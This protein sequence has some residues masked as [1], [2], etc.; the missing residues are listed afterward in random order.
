MFYLSKIAWAFFQPSTFIAVVFVAGL[1]LALAGRSRFGTWLLAAATLLYLICG[2]SPLGVWLLEPL[3]SWASPASD[4]ELS[5][6]AGIIVLGGG[7]ARTVKG[8]APQLNEAGERMV[9]TVRLARRFPSMTIVF[10][11]GR[12]E[13][14]EDESL[15]TEA[16]SA[17]QFLSV[18]DIS[19]PR[20]KL[21]D[22]SRNTFENAVF[23][24]RVVA[25][26]PGQPWILVTSAF[27]MPRAALL[28]EKQG[29]TIL[30]RPTDFRTTSGVRPARFFLRAGQGFDQVD[31]A[32]K[33]WVAI[34]VYWLRG[35]I[36]WP[37]KLFCGIC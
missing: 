7:M 23:T 27:H 31:L 22:S 21:E 13:L 20:L 16:A 36:A 30:Q 33:E 9:E 32:A 1:A 26:A 19:A 17:E 5:G 6:A 18:F 37:K 35:D 11:G 29:F 12:G 34:F 15:Q 14:F 28:F 4:A 2:F 25:P 3:E 24:A 10:S 8:A